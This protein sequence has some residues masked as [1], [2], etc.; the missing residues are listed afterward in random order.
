[1]RSVV[2]VVTP[3]LRCPLGPDE[4]VGASYRIG[5]PAVLALP[6]LDIGTPKGVFLV[7]PVLRK[8][9][10]LLCLRL[11]QTLQL[12]CALDTRLLLGQL[13][14][15]QRLLLQLLFV[16]R[17]LQLLLEQLRGLLDRHS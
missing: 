6:R 3:G 5:T 7:L 12:L 14:A 2:P 11:S 16:L 9:Q 1:M 15:A 4:M 10:A 8:P 13:A 17:L